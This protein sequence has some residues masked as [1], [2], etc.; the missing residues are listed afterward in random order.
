MGQ[1]ARFSFL[2]CILREP[3]KPQKRKAKQFTKREEK[4]FLTFLQVVFFKKT[5]I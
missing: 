1:N 3:Y 4:A 5:Q 2:K